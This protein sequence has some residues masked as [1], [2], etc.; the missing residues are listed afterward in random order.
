MNNSEVEKRVSGHEKLIEMLEA[1]RTVNRAIKRHYETINGFTGVHF[2]NIRKKAEHDLEIQEKV[3]KR[4][5][6]RYNSYLKSLK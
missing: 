4:F 1:I 6:Q 2:A 5:E 3:K